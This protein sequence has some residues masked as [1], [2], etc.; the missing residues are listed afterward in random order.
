MVV[1]YFI[2]L[3]CTRK[4]KI[5]APL[6][7]IFYSAELL[8]F[9]LFLLRDFAGVRKSNSLCVSTTLD[10]LGHKQD[11]KITV[12]LLLPFLSGASPS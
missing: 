5:P 2:K 9:F 7:Y 12:R 3:L 10:L 8:F 1:F 4:K 11:A 6:E